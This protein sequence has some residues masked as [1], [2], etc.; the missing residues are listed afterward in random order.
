MSSSAQCPI[1]IFRDLCLLSV[2]LM[3]PRV[4]ATTKIH[5]RELVPRMANLADDGVKMR[6]ARQWPQKGFAFVSPFVRTQKPNVPIPIF[7]FPPAR[8]PS[9]RQ[10]TVLR[11]VL[12]KMVF[13]VASSL[14]LTLASGGIMAAADGQFEFTMG[15]TQKNAYKNGKMQKW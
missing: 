6:K 7:T 14:Y 8:Q 4:Q 13:V 3:L 11:F 9:K 5:L 2:M 10:Q 1:D 12:E 15:D